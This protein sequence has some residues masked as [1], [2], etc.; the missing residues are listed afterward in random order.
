MVILLLQV[1]N[2]QQCWGDLVG[3]SNK[4]IV[5]DDIIAILDWNYLNYVVLWCNMWEI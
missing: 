4:V 3:M 1:L 2:D 5:P